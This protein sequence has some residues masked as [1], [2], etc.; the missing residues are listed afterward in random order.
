MK[1]LCVLCRRI[2]NA[3]HWK[4]GEYKTVDGLRWGWICSRWY[5]PK[6]YEFVPQRI[7]DERVK[8]RK[9]ILQPYRSG[10]LSREFVEAYP[11]QVKKMIKSGAVT[12]REVAKSMPVWKGDI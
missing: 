11:S 12:K 9:E 3:T 1:Q 6:T 2:H 10:E 8:Y 4:Y 7:K 5:K